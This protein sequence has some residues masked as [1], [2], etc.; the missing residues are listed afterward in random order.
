MA[1]IIVEGNDGACYRGRKRG[2][3]AW[4]LASIE[5][6]GM[7]GVALDYQV[8][9]LELWAVRIPLKGEYGSLKNLIF[10]F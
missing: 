9:Q 8:E 10:H 7:G 5:V 2:W 4:I 1:W 6:A 3:S